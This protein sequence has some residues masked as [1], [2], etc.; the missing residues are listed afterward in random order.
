MY[1]QVGDFGVS[2]GLTTVPLTRISCNTGFSKSQSARKA[3]TLCIVFD[4]NLLI[5]FIYSVQKQTWQKID[6]VVVSTFFFRF[7]DFEH[8]I[9]ITGWWD[10]HFFFNFDQNLNDDCYWFRYPFCTSNKMPL[11]G[12]IEK[13][14]NP[15]HKR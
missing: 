7:A 14:L 9:I 6:T 13:T 4:L 15:S 10:W 1:A 11:F 5:M 12:L 8:V 2:K 3:E